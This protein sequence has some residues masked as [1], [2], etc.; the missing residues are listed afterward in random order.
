MS[1]RGSV[2]VGGVDDDHIR[3]SVPDFFISGINAL[4]EQTFNFIKKSALSSSRSSSQDRDG[5]KLF[6]TFVAV[7]KSFCNSRQPSVAIPESLDS[8]ITSKKFKVA[9]EGFNKLKRSNF[10]LVKETN[11]QIKIKGVLGFGSVAM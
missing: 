10:D 1:G 6:V 11:L 8:F 2:P 4:N 7:F 3:E 9:A 5:M